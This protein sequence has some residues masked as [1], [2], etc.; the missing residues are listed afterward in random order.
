MRAIR[1]LELFFHVHAS[2]QTMI[3]SLRAGGHYSK[4]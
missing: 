3:M 2:E 4:I 1:N